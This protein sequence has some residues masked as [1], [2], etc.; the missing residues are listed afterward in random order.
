[1]TSN[2]DR[3][4]KDLADLIARGEKLE[5]A[6][7]QEFAPR[8]S[9]QK[10]KPCLI[11][12][13]AYQTWYSEA[14]ATIKL[15]LPDRLSDFV[16]HYEPPKRTNLTLETFRIADYLQHLKVFSLDFG[17]DFEGDGRQALPHF[18]QQLAILRAAEK[19]F[20]STLFE[21]GSSCKLTSSTRSLT[22]RTTWQK[23]DSFVPPVRWPV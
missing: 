1:M 4:R 18:T 7:K 5:L 21:S 13:E 19:R 8:K 15:L 16:S 2:L 20:T 10:A 6:L 11:V 14:R 3:F 17:I 23:K 12:R 9:Q 22:L